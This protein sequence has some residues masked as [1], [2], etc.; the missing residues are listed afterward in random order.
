MA[1]AAGAGISIHQVSSWTV[2]TIRPR[3]GGD[4][5]DPRRAAARSPERAARGMGRD[6][7]ALQVVR[8]RSA[9]REAAVRALLA[10]RS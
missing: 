1:P 8:E 9:E 7:A 10:W 3:P 2:A 4:A 6:Q 5:G